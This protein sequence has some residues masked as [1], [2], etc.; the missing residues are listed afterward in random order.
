MSSPES[1][2]DFRDDPLGFLDEA[3]KS[4]REA[5]WLPGRRLCLVDAEASKAVLANS[6]GLY[7]EHG[8]FFHTRRGLFGPREAQVRIARAGRALLRD[9]LTARGGR[10]AQSVGEVLEQPSQ[11]PD[12]G[13]WVMYRHLGEVLLAPGSPARLRGTLEAVVRRGVLAGAKQRYSL[14]SRALFRFRVGR[15]LKQEIEL[16]RKRGITQPADMLDVVISGAEPGAPAADLVE[17][18]LSFVFAVVGS[19]GLLL[20]WSVYL[21]GTNPPTDAQ[22]AWVVR[23]ALRLWPV[24]WFLGARPAKSHQV[25]G[26]AVTPEDMVVVCP[27]AVQRSAS[28]WDEPAEFRPERWATLKNPQAFLPFGWGPHT[29]PASL[30]ALELVEDILRLLLDGHQIRVTPHD[31]RPCVTAALAPPKFTMSRIFS[32]A[33]KI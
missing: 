7:E 5:F 23:E 26:V 25:A 32:F 8:D 10:L 15:Q 21:L 1:T 20:G 28:N 4:A 11:W 30:L 2:V 27:Y 14:L 18:F 12:A 9:Y 19:L 6:E 24:A 3:V 16:R 13:N 29:C 17:V 22:P 31:T 33:G